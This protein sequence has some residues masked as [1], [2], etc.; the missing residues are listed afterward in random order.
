MNDRL[1]IAL[2]IGA[3]NVGGSL[4]AAKALAYAREVTGYTYE[5]CE[6]VWRGWA[7]ANN[8]PADCTEINMLTQPSSVADRLRASFDSK[9]AEYR[10]TLEQR[11]GGS[12]HYCDDPAPDSIDHIVPLSREG[13]NDIN[14]L[15]LACRP[16]NTSKGARIYPDE[17]QGRGG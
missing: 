7:G 4:G 13:T 15:V 8:I 12:C 6:W 10:V 2:I 9:K 1:L 3:D 16:C 17:W 14:N 11:D 5:E